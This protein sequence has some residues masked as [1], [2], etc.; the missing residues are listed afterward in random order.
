MFIT[1]VASSATHEECKTIKFLE[2]SELN[3]YHANVLPLCY[4]NKNITV[5]DVLK[6]FPR[7]FPLA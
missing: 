4:W 3:I 5:D 1:S 6:Q 7:I 2:Y